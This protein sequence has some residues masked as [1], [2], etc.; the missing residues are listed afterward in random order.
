MTDLKQLVTELHS[1]GSYPSNTKTRP[2]LT[3]IKAHPDCSDELYEQINAACVQEAGWIMGGADFNSLEDMISALTT[4]DK[5][6]LKVYTDGYCGH[7]IRAY[8]YFGDQMPDIDP[9]SVESINS[10][11]DKYP[12][13]R[14]DSKVPTFAL[15]YLGTWHTLVSNLGLT[16]ELAKRI[17][18]NYHELYKESDAWTAKKLEIASKTGYVEGAFGLRVRTPMLA[19]TI[20]GKKSTPYEAQKES[21]TAGNALGQSYGMLNNR[22]AI[23]FQDRVLKSP[24]AHDI[25]PIGMIH[26][27]IYFIFTDKMDVVKWINKNLIG[28]MQWQELDEIKHGTVKLGAGLELFPTWADT[29]KIPNDATNQQILAAVQE[30]KEGNK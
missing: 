9:N 11:A 20:L 16:E 12:L 15:T 13:L 22:A 4:R 14:Q 25:K 28:C 29:V 10:I 27:A 7:C 21:R 18:K 23:E 5:N 8:S 24:Y 19:Q 1:L 6:K 3:N 2:L 17:E 26:D 30:Y